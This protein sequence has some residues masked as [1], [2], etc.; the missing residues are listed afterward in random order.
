MTHS[1][2]LR[3]RVNFGIRKINKLVIQSYPSIHHRKVN[4][5]SICSS[6]PVA[7]SFFTCTKKRMRQFRAKQSQTIYQHHSYHSFSSYAKWPAR[8]HVCACEFVELSSSCRIVCSM[9]QHNT[10]FPSLRLSNHSAS[11]LSVDCLD[12]SVHCCS[13][14]N[15]SSIKPLARLCCSN[16]KLI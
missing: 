7:L 1:E 16:S 10:L 13:C 2:Q 15:Q 12:S 6:V 9:P 8:A 5:Q 3:R 11:T 14:S 4:V